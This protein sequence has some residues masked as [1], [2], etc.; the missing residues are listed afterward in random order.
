MGLFI[1]H[2]GI[3]KMAKITLTA[4]PT[5]SAPVPIPVPGVGPVNVVFTF[6]G[7]TRAQL[8]E[9]TA[10]TTGD[11]SLENADLILELACGWELDEPFDLENVTKLT[12]NYLGATGAIYV[13]Y[14]QELTEA[15][16]KN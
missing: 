2:S 14:L 11:G 5:F 12:E 9:F 16:T 13:T 6:K 1:Q 3:T 4:A 7:R 8:K 15:R 10:R